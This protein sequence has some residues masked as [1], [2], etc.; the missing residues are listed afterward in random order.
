MG[1]SIQRA[2]PADVPALQAFNARLRAGGVL[3]FKLPENA[4]SSWL[5]RRG[6]HALYEELW[7]A[8]EGDEVR[9]G[10]ILKHQP[11]RIGQEIVSVGYLYSPV[12]EALVDSRYGALGLQILLHAQRQQPL[13]YC[14]GMGGLDRPLPRLLK[15]SRWVLAPVPFLFYPVRPAI[16]FRELPL[17]QRTPARAWLARASASTG[18]AWLGMR[19]WQLC[20]QR[21]PAKRVETIEI[22]AFGPWADELWQA[23]ASHYGFIAERNSSSLNLLYPTGH[24]RFLKLQVTRE[25]K[26]TG[27]VVLLDT[28]MQNSRH[29][30]N[31]R[32]G[33]VVDLLAA[34]GEEATVAWAATKY[35]ERRGVDLIITNQ[36]HQAWL[37]AF[38]CAGWLPGPSNFI[39]AAAPKLAEKLKPWPQVC[40]QAHLTRGDGEGPTHL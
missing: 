35:L 34:P 10:Y 20:R 4:E 18:L 32:V 1:I 26:I 19:C 5:P 9:G 11:F 6:D 24:P 23:A 29:F 7:V 12:S 3:D 8:K 30:G 14:L 31:L 2:S 22:N 33:S 17:L 38:R 13:L 16:I 27:W 40:T 21:P 36:A 15:A 37:A 28:P 25:K 39:F